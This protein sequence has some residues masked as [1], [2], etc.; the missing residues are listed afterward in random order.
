MLWT[1]LKGIPG[2][3]KAVFGL[4]K[5]L[6]NYSGIKNAAPRTF[7]IGT[8]TEAGSIKFTTGT[9][10]SISLWQVIIDGYQVDDPVSEHG[11][12]TIKLHSIQGVNYHPDTHDMPK[13]EAKNAAR[14][15]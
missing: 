13:S 15:G 12:F 4:T 6:R 2:A 5:Y 1:I 10:R 8:K 3:L 9:V 7:T 11:T 14:E